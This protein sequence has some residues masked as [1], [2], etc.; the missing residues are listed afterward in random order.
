MV[1]TVRRGSY[2]HEVATHHLWCQGEAGV[3]L[4]CYRNEA[5]VVG[6]L[7]RDVLTSEFRP[8]LLTCAG[9]LACNLA[10]YS[11]LSRCCFCLRTLHRPL[12]AVLPGI[13]RGHARLDEFDCPSLGHA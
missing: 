10:L 1:A 13:R 3:P 4:H 9:I 11:Q 6:T 5:V 12:S 2:R 8:G 7:L